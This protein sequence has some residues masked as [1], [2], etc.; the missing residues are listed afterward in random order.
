MKFSSILDSIY[1]RR[2]HEFN[3]KLL[4]RFESMSKELTDLFELHMYTSSLKKK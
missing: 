4:C 1:T 3:Q 2:M